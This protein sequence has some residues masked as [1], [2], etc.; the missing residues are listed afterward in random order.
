MR[1]K[2]VKIFGV[3]SFFVQAKRTAMIIADGD[4]KV[5]MIARDTF[6]LCGIFVAL[7]KRNPSVPTMLW[8]PENVIQRHV[9]RRC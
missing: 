8:V 4:V 9:L 6:I 3:M 7:K 2:L 1:L 5:G